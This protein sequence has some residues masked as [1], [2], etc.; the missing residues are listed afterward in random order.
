[1]KKSNLKGELQFEND[2]V[3]VWKTLV[4][5]DELLTLGQGSQIVVGVQSGQ[6]QKLSPQGESQV[7]HIEPHQAYWIGDHQIRSCQRPIEVMVIEMKSPRDRLLPSM[8]ID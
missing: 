2:Q 8:P 5:D 3:C 7:L 4:Q 1:M 6:I